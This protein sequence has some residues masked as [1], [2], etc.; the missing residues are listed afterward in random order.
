MR[1]WDVLKVV[2]TVSGKNT[3]IYCEANKFKKKFQR[4]GKFCS[5]ISMWAYWGTILNITET[6]RGSLQF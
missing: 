6:V 1:V 2:G 3:L 5:I 4:M